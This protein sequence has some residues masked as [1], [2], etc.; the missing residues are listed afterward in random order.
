[1]LC[2]GATASGAARQF[3][4]QWRCLG[5]VIKAFQGVLG[6][7]FR[8]LLVSERHLKYHLV[9]S[10]VDRMELAFKGIAKRKFQ[11]DFKMIP[12]KSEET[13]RLERLFCVSFK[14]VAEFIGINRGW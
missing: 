1:M 5:D 6:A 7:L 4:D 3:M 8:S 10:I 14:Y 11:F 9:L 13:M 12:K 2:Q